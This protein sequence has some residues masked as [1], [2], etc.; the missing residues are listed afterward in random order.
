M[1]KAQIQE[2]LQTETYGD[3]N[4]TSGIRPSYDLQ[5]VPEEG[6][7]YTHVPE[8]PQQQVLV[9]AASKEHLV[10]IFHELVINFGD[11]VDIALESTHFRTPWVKSV[12]GSIAGSE[13]IKW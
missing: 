4:L 9:C 2:H 13:S 10:R 8:M 12:G 5:V 7:R 1:S 11:V 6:F 3:F